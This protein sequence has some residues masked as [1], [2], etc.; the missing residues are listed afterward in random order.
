MLPIALVIILVLAGAAVMAVLWRILSR[1]ATTA[2]V[3]LQSLSQDYVLKQDELKQRLDQSEKSYQDQLV[4]LRTEGDAMKRK[5]A[6]E[7]EAI[8]QK[9]AAQG[10]DEYEKLVQKGI[11]SR[12]AMKREMDQLIDVKAIDRAG[13]LLQK[14]LPEDFRQIVQQQWVEQLLDNGL[15]DVSRFPSQGS[16]KESKEAKVTSA[17]P[18][19][20]QQRTKLL[21]RLRAALGPDV[22]LRESV[23]AAMVAGLSI[24][25]GQVVLDGS[26]VGKLREA[27]KDA[28]GSDE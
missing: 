9:L 27:V 16:A 10:R 24:S 17:F 7:A 11:E 26:L 21:E 25:V 2:T 18:L 20:A 1:H 8:R 4:K 6:E 15:I 19:T 23:D 3:H 14:L 12:D 22:V 28:R 13:S 5:A